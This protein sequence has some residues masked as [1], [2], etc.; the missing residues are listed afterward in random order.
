ML[1]RG[2]LGSRCH[3]LCC[4]MDWLQ[5]PEVLGGIQS[6]TKRF[7]KECAHCDSRA[8]SGDFGSGVEATAPGRP[9]AGRSRV[10]AGPRGP[11]PLRCGQRPG[12]GREPFQGGMLPRR[13]VATRGLRWM[14]L[15][16]LH[17]AQGSRHAGERVIL[18]LRTGPTRGGWGT[19]PMASA[20][21]VSRWGRAGG[22]GLP[23][24][25]QSRDR[26]ASGVGP[27]EFQ[28]GA[29]SAETIQARRSR[30]WRALLRPT[31]GAP[32]FRDEGES[33]PPGA[34]RRG[35]GAISGAGRFGLPAATGRQGL[36]KGFPGRAVL[37]H[38][39]ASAWQKRRGSAGRPARAAASFCCCP[40]T[41]WGRSG[42][43]PR[44]LRVKPQAAP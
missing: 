4:G 43:G 22:R 32:R 35:W 11:W 30:N 1:G 9:V 6:A 44:G 2:R 25:L 14:G 28:A 7:P 12:P 19:A 34:W 26:P 17:E 42:V 3:P 10:A 16:G 21:L 20:W 24:M 39:A 38:H 13:G 23:G 31:G 15:G 41:A 37:A 33:G 36:P 18:R 27:A 40:R 29:G 5:V 8:R